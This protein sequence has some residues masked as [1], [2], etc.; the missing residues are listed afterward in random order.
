MI[1]EEDL[2]EAIAECQGKRNPDANT[3]I[4]MAA[5][6]T[7]KNALY[8]DKSQPPEKESDYYQLS[9][10]SSPETIEYH[11]DSDFSRMVNGRSASE[12]MPI[13]DELMDTLRMIHPK[14]YTGVMNRL[15]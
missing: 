7:I 9:S 15:R 1:K 6:L 10:G 3:C 4:K 5:Y 12:I 11:S 8:P 13:L 14:L 2:K